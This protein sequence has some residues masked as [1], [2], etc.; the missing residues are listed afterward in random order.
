MKNALCFFQVCTFSKKNILVLYACNYG[1][2]SSPNNVVRPQNIND[3]LA[4]Y[5]VN[6]M[7]TSYKI[8]PEAQRT[9]GIASLT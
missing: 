4:V 5:D 3:M 8:L 2:R 6:L 7:I 9:Q 1:I